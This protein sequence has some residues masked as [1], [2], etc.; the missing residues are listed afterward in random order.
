MKRLL[1]VSVLVSVGAIFF[2]G[3]GEQPAY[4]GDGGEGSGEYLEN[5]K[6]SDQQVQ[7]DISEIRSALLSYGQANNSFPPSLENLLPQYLEE[8]PVSP[9]TNQPYEYQGDLL[10][11]DY[12]LK[13]ELSNGK[14]YTANKNTTDLEWKDDFDKPGL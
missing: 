13:Y 8:I 1:V 9:I 10:G 14:I 5:T 7:A 12:E 6:G 11:A 2:T 3:C 4:F